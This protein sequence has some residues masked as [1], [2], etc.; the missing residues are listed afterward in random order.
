M[1]LLCPF[2]F[3]V[4]AEEKSMRLGGYCIVGHP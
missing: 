1:S 3:W 4:V 2:P